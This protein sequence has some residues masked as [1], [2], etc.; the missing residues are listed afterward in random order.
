MDGNLGS[1][2]FTLGLKDDDF[3]T[4]MQGLTAQVEKALNGSSSGSLSPFKKM[5]K[6]V[7]E[8]IDKTR[9]LAVV[10]GIVDDGYKEAVAECVKLKK[11][12]DDI[13]A[14]SLGLATSIDK[15]N[16]ARDQ[17][18]AKAQRLAELESKRLQKE[19]ELAEKVAALKIKQQRADENLVQKI[20]DGRSKIKAK[21]EA[22]AQASIARTNRIASAQKQALNNS[23]SKGLT[24]SMLE[25]TN[26]IGKRSDAIKSLNS[27]Y[28]DQE[29]ITKKQAQASD[30]AAAAAAK[31]AKA[32]KGQGLSLFFSNGEMKTSLRLS[33]SLTSQMGALFSIYAAERFLK[34]LVE[35]RGEFEMQQI[36][37]RAI[38]RDAE[39]ADKIFAQLQGLAV[40]SPFQFKDLVSYAK[41]LSAFSVPIEELYGTTK[42]LADISSGLGVDMS[43]IIIAY[44]QVKSAAVLR[45]QELRQFTEAG[46]PLVDELA[47]KFTELS[48]TVTTTGEVFD[49]ISKREVPFTMVKGIFEDMTSAGGKFYNMQEKQAESLK[50][51]M[52]NLADAFQISMNRIGQSQDGVLKGGVDFA[53]SLAKNFETVLQVLGTVVVAIGAYKAAQGIAFGVTAAKGLIE[54]IRLISM[55]RKEMGTLTA[56]QKAF[57][58]AS[59]QNIYIAIAQVIATISAAIW[60]FNTFSKSVRSA[61]EVTDDLTR[62]TTAL[63][64]AGEPAK[65]LASQYAELTTRLES[66]TLTADAYTEAD[67]RRKVVMT[68]LQKLTADA[69]ITE[70]AYGAIVGINTEAIDRYTEAEKRGAAN[71]LKI[72]TD[73]AGERVKIIKDNLKA[74]QF[75][76]DNERKLIES[77]HLSVVTNVGKV[78]VTSENLIP[79][80]RKANQAYLRDLNKAYNDALAELNKIEPGYDAA[81]SRLTKLTQDMQADSKIAM[82]RHVDNLTYWLDKATDWT[83]KWNKNADKVKPLMPGQ[84]PST[85]QMVPDANGWQQQINKKLSSSSSIK[86]SGITSGDYLAKEEE[87]ISEYIKRIGQLRDEQNSL[88]IAEDNAFKK[89]KIGSQASVDGLKAQR[90][91]Y[92]TILNMLDAKSKAEVKG[93]SAASRARKAREKSEKEALENQISLIKEAYAEYEKLNKAGYSKESAAKTVMGYKRYEKIAISTAAG[94]EG[95]SIDTVTS[96]VAKAHPS[97]K[98]IQELAKKDG[99]VYYDTLT[100][101]SV[102]SIQDMFDSISTQLESYKSKYEFFQQLIGGGINQTEAIGIAFGADYNGKLIPI[103]EFILSQIKVAADTAKEV[104]FT[105]DFKSD[106]TFQDQLGEAYKELSDPVK[107]LIDE[108]E[109]YRLDKQKEGWM[110][111][112]K[113]TNSEVPE[114]SGFA[115]NVSGLVAKMNNAITEINNSAAKAMLSANDEQDKVIQNWKTNAIAA[116]NETYKQKIENL[117]SVYIKQELQNSQLWES[118]SNMSDASLSEVRKTLTELGKIQQDLLS[119]GGI[120]KI[121]SGAISDADKK[122]GVFGSAMSYLSSSTDEEDLNRRILELK[123][124]IYTANLNIKTTGSD[125]SGFTEEQLKTLELILS[126]LGKINPAIDNAKQK[127][128]QVEFEKWAK[129]A[130]DATSSIAGITGGIKGFAEAFGVEFDDTEKAAFELVD[131]LANSTDNVIS[132]MV[133]A[134]LAA[135]TQMA[136]TSAAASGGIVATSTVAS[137]AIKTVESASVILAII[138]AAIQVAT[139]IVNIFTAASKKRKEVAEK[140]AEAQRQAYLGLIDYNIALREQYDWTKKISE[141]RLEWYKREGDELSRQIETNKELQ[142]TLSWSQAAHDLRY[143][144]SQTKT[145]NSTTTVYDNLA[146]KSVDDLAKLVAQGRLDQAGIDFYELMKKAAD[147]GKDLAKAQDEYFESV[148]EMFT[149]TTYQTIADSIIDGFKEG[150]RSAADFADTFEQLMQG[151][152]QAALSLTADAGI[153]KWY[154]DFATASESGGVLTPE[155]QDALKLSWERLIENLGVQADSLEAITGKAIS[156]TTSASGLKGEVSSTTE[157]TSSRLVGLL[158]TIRADVSAKNAN[159]KLMVDAHLGGGIN[160]FDSKA[161]AQL[162][163]LNAK[164]AASNVMVESIQSMIG[165]VITQGSKGKAFRVV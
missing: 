160:V 48:G 53:M 12:L 16:K 51:K 150:K 3:K 34:S 43:R 112:L 117:G 158:N 64:E 131:T 122:S 25:T 105:L 110:E 30:K 89:S 98:A 39:G 78:D 70:G 62:S 153:R 116:E 58:I 81:M 142:N 80:N 126:I 140:E 75:A 157:A 50:G 124:Q 114:G 129:G 8:V 71:R 151:A 29:R 147:E 118:Y 113:I 74:I 154:E 138:S 128:E 120:N 156:S 61:Q 111:Y 104:P 107:K 152:V 143:V 44:G 145:K 20:L 52:S 10:S 32:Q 91:G 5:S 86:G 96:A 1:L 21:E 24:G 159:L 148:R 19:Q 132:A 165:S 101:V 103:N 108:S 85:W 127:A 28:R 68:E 133:A 163:D 15:E 56:A 7:S 17:G 36:A 35:I 94:G 67:K 135:S 146:G 100:D 65:K 90:D 72:T 95:I 54:N 33:S 123:A 106:K 55:Y 27:Y 26:D 130:K 121:A 109:K 69:V 45:G 13:K 18:I 93:E 23:I 73:E 82:N 164:M 161:N 92:D 162:I 59:K 97:N 102:K 63:D 22:D 14:S 11:E 77:S 4:K 31:H 83:S 87:S 88:Y 38:L 115:F 37:L 2:Y 40:K 99:K 137:T 9:S 136:A 141:T 41:Q 149:G 76:I 60:A 155:E 49:K 125:I 139:A 46:I 42:T 134:S 79:S 6:D 84:I 57:N 66:G 144:Y 47:K 119:G